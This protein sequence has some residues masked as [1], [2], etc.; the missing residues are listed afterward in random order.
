MIIGPLLKDQ[1]EELLKSNP[2]VPVLALNELDKPIVNDNTFYFS[3]AAADASRRPSTSMV[4][5][6]ASRC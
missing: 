6:T 3:L 2:T 5:A 1:V 4:R